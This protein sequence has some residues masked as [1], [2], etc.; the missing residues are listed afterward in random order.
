MPEVV[1]SSQAAAALLHPE[2]RRILELLREPDSASALA[3]RLGFARQR[4]NYHLKELE[5]AGLVRLVEERRKGN[6]VERI[7]QATS[8][9]YVIG[10]E[11]LGSLG[12]HPGEVQDRF[13]AAYLIQTAGLIL[14]DLGELLRR[15]RRENKRLPSLTLE[16]EIRFASPKDRATFSQELAEQFAALVRKYHAP[17]APEGRDFRLIAAAYP[18]ITHSGDSHVRT[19][20]DGDQTPDRNPV[21]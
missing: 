5:Q 7:L 8:T 19:E 12:M 4:L 3:R 11:A 1:N 16:A 15:A 20:P 18:A 6:C 13:S 10:P 9:S 21:H 14:R 2:R 17:K